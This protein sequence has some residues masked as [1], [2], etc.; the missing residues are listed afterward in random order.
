MAYEL[1]N[2][3]LDDLHALPMPCLDR[4]RMLDMAGRL[5]RHPALAEQPT[6]FA[7]AV[8]HWLRCSKRRDRRIVDATDLWHRPFAEE[9]H[10]LFDRAQTSSARLRSDDPHQESLRSLRLQM[11]RFSA[12][13]QLI[14]SILRDTWR[15]GMASDRLHGACR[16]HG[17]LAYHGRGSEV[18]IDGLAESYASVGKPWDYPRHRFIDAVEAGRFDEAHELWAGLAPDI[19]SQSLSIYYAA[20]LAV[21]DAT[22][23]GRA[24]DPG[25]INGAIQRLST[26]ALSL[27]ND[28]RLR[29][30]VCTGDRAGIEA[31]AADP[32]EYTMSQWNATIGIEAKALLGDWDG[33]RRLLA[34]REGA[35]IHII[36][37]GILA[38]AAHFA[39]GEMDDAA[40][41]LASAEATGRRHGS[42]GRGELLLRILHSPGP[43]DLLA[44]G[45][46]VPRRTATPSA[47]AP[48]EDPD[49]PLAGS[50]EALTRVR[51]QI[52]RYALFDLPVLISGP[53]GVGKDLVARSLH[54]V[55]P[56]AKR[57]F[58]AC[59]CA[60]ITSGLLEAELFGHVRGAFTGA[61]RARAGLIDEARDGTLFLDEIGDAS[62]EFQA[63]MLRLLD[64]GE[65]RPVGSAQS[66]RALCR[67]VCATNVDL[68]VAVASG[69]FRGDLL[70]RLRRLEIL[71]PPLAERP[72]DLV[73]I[74][75]RLLAGMSADRV[76]A[77][78]VGPWLRK[79]PWPGNAREL[80][81]LLERVCAEHAAGP[82]TAAMLDSCANE[83]RHSSSGP[84]RAI[85]ATH[86]LRR[87]R[88]APGQSA[89]VQAPVADAPAEA[90]LDRRLAR[91]AELIRSHGTITRKAFV[92]VLGI[93]PVTATAYLRVLCDRGQVRRIEPS[94]SVATHYFE[95]VG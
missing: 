81:G 67:F 84:L 19:Q 31:A 4:Q 57:P 27:A 3:L 53:S 32:N 9:L 40:V 51:T 45:R 61:D 86:G 59:N 37:D 39:A 94:G 65:Y 85:S 24:I 34:S 69:H 62:P 41:A 60:A 54:R 50:S 33:V 36:S 1:L 71:I 10:A 8:A 68:D 48:T 66:R 89:P 20:E 63:A 6:V 73:P 80:R 35:G 92:Q 74:A 77:E 43:F 22:R 91:A 88:S 17:F 79:R 83:V 42:L 44:L 7:D 90:A 38:A 23:R 16:L 64:H 76:L 25:A 29:L 49:D 56:R 15:H 26:D 47:T 21:L 18:P 82:V 11:A 78:D 12:S 52:T 55:S 95:W 14:E 93:S 58:V 87:E 46:R 72:D 5:A 13:F 28:L 2:V 70:Y 75:C 30:A